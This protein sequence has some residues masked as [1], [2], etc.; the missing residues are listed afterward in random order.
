MSK[1]GIKA[2]ATILQAAQNIRIKLLG[3]DNQDIRLGQL[4][5]RMKN[6][7]KKDFCRVTIEE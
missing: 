5:D 1:N 6:S 7:V 3:G 2:F 4:L